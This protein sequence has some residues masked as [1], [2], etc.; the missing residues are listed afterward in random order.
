MAGCIVVLRNSP[1][2]HLDHLIQH[3]QPKEVTANGS[4]YKSYVKRW[5]ET[6]KSY[7]IKLNDKSMEGAFTLN[8]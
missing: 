8:P 4:N 1:K 6:C 3:L 2:V 5:E 7:R